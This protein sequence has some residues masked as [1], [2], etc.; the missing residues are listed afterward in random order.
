MELDADFVSGTT[1][2]VPLGSYYVYIPVHDMLAKLLG[3]GKASVYTVFFSQ[4]QAAEQV[5]A[6]T[7]PKLL[8][9]EEKERIRGEIGD[10]RFTMAFGR[11]LPK[12]VRQGIGAHHVGMLSKYRR[13]VERPFQTGPLRITCG[14]G[15]LGVGINVPTRAVLITDLVKFDGRYSR[16]PKS[17]EFHQI[18]E[19]AGCTGYDIGGIVVVEAPEHKIEDAKLRCRAG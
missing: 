4:R 9:E 10:F 15:T 6:L 3:S 17:R 13:L 8:T 16:T 1:C 5:Q 7:G 14:M 12:L 18:T 19:R 2:P 11:V